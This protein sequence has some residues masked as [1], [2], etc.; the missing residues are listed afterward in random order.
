MFRA[1]LLLATALMACLLPI[2]ALFNSAARELARFSDWAEIGWLLAGVER[3]M[4][5]K[6]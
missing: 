3:K 2:A 6:P 1:L 4:R 5:R